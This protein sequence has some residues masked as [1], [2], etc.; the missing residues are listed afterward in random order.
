MHIDQGFFSNL[1]V[2]DDGSYSL[3]KPTPLPVK[4]VAY[5]GK[6]RGDPNKT[7][8]WYQTHVLEPGVSTHTIYAWAYCE[9]IHLSFPL[10]D[11]PKSPVYTP[12]YLVIVPDPVH[13]LQIELHEIKA[14][15]GKWS[16][17]REAA[18]LRM[19]LAKIRYPQFVWKR[20]DIEQGQC[21]VTIL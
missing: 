3:K 14:K 19:K 17:A 20:V 7:E 8:H 6:R 1:I 13:F 18:V 21:H 5:S 11:A 4:T 2:E 15:R 16:S 9:A 10:S 12:D